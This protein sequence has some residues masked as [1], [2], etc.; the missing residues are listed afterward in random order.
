MRVL[1]WR[2]AHNDHVF[3]AVKSTVEQLVFLFTLGAHV[4]R[5]YIYTLGAHAQRGYCSCVCVCVCL[6]LYISLT[7]MFV[8]LTNGMTYLTGNEGQKYERFSSE[9]APLQS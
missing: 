3:F 2:V 9:N 5:G 4:Q 7:R 1:H 8:R 6:L